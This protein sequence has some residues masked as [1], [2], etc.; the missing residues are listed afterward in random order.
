MRCRRVAMLIPFLGRCLKKRMMGFYPTEVNNEPYFPFFSFY[1]NTFLLGGNF[2]PYFRNVTEGF[3][4][5]RMVSRVNGQVTPPPSCRTPT[6]PYHWESNIL[7][8]CKKDGK[9]DEDLKWDE[10]WPDGGCDAGHRTTI[11]I[12]F[13][14]DIEIMVTPLALESLQRFIESLTA[15]VA[16]LHPLTVV[17]HLHYECIGRVKDANVLKKDEYLSGFPAS[18][19]ILET[20]TG[21]D[22]TSSVSRILQSHVYQQS[23]TSQTQ[24]VVVFPKISVTLLQASV[25]EE[26]TPF[27]A[28][29]NVRDFACVSVFA[30]CLDKV[31][32]KFHLE[33]QV[34]LTWVLGVFLIICFAD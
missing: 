14:G 24:G 7:S 30:I 13:Q 12:R 6:H 3:T 11:I 26:L 17:N 5:L 34:F 27:S 32:A 28:L 15:T 16:T 23:I 20:K 9:A 29:D 33:K 25:V 2:T 31:T 18:G 22:K 19:S 8:E 4:Y 21:K 10:E 1:L